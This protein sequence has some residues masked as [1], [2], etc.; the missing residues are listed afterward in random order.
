MKQT[1]VIGLKRK[2]HLSTG[3]QEILEFR[4]KWDVFIGTSMLYIAVV[5]FAVLANVCCC[6]LL[7][8]LS[9]CFFP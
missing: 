6:L 7:F 9:F 5:I 8:P 4:I 1:G 2:E 3:T